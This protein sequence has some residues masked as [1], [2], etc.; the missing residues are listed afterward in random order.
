MTLSVCSCIGDTNTHARLGQSWVSWSELVTAGCMNLN[1]LLRTG[2]PQF[3]QLLTCPTARTVGVLTDSCK[4]HTHSLSEGNQFRLDPAFLPGEG[5]AWPLSPK[6][7]P[8]KSALCQET[9]AAAERYSLC[10]SVGDT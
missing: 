6:L 3:P 4:N 10:M 2:V 1:M 9:Q 5:P 7:E 8:G